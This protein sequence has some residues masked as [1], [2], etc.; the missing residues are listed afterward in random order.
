MGLAIQSE[1]IPMQA[2]SDGTVR[3]GGTRVT[4]DTVISA[5]VNG[6]TPQDIARQYPTIQL[7]DIYTVL[8]YYLRHT[9]EVETYLHER[10]QKAEQ[11]RREMGN[12]FDP[13]DVR[14]RL[15]QRR[16]QSAE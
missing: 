12:R 9:S 10:Q 16:K 8:A 7:A 2:D 11:I 3:I 15:E 5:H 6:A 13:A 14:D 4:L 1:P